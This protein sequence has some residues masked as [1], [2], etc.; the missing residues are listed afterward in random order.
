[1]S[2]N[3]VTLSMSFLGGI[4]LV[5]PTCLTDLLFMY[6]KFNS[7]ALFIVPMGFQ[8]AKYIANKIIETNH[9]MYN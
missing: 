9:I 6:S 2:V 3:Y 8:L 1:M 7:S 4:L 5:G